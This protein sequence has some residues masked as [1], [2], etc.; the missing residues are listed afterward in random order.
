M[1]V[2]ESNVLCVCV[3]Q[4]LKYSQADVDR[5]LKENEREWMRK[6]DEQKRKC[7]DL[8]A[9]KLKS[10]ERVI[11]LQKNLEDMKYVSS[12]LELSLSL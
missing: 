10:E 3:E 6:L 8:S 4:V 11:M 7:G 1:S 5:M 2:P 12:S 9:E